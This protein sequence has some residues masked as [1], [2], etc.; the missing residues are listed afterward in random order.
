M[1]QSASVGE[2]VPSLDGIR[3]ENGSQF[4]SEQFAGCCCGENATVVVAVG[5]SG[6]GLEMLRE[7]PSGEEMSNK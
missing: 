5:G 1:T 4:P 7:M 3:E 6:G 2:Q